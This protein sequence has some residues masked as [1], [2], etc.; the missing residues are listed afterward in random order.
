V[1]DQVKETIRTPVVRSVCT[2]KP[3]SSLLKVIV[4]LLSRNPTV[5]SWDKEG[6]SVC[7]FRKPTGL[8]LSAVLSALTSDLQVLDKKLLASLS[9][10]LF[11]L[12]FPRKLVRNHKIITL[13]TAIDNATKKDIDGKSIPV[14][15]LV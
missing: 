6:N 10:A 12:R 3:T 1:E 11:K 8:T 5:I 2:K 14:K 4:K 13:L 7:L 15:N 9:L